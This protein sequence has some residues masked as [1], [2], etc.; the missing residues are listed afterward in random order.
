VP[1]GRSNT[2][3]SQTEPDAAE[4]PAGS[5]KRWWA[6]VGGVTAAVFLGDLGQ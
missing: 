2:P 1:D 4:R 6:V 5:W 3:L